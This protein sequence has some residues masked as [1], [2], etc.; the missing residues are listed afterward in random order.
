MRKVL[1]ILSAIVILISILPVSSKAATYNV[2]IGDNLFWEL[3]TESGT[4]V[5][6]GEGAMTE[7]IESSIPWEL[8]FEIS[9]LSVKH[10]II[11]EGV[12]SIAHCA[13]EEFSNLESVVI[14]HTVT[15]I[16][17]NAFY[18]CGK[19]A[20]VTIPDSVTSI[21]EYAFAFCS[22]YIVE[23]IPDSV[24][25]IGIDAFR[26]CVI[27]SD[28]I[29]PKNITELQG[30]TGSKFKTLTIPDSVKRIGCAAFS[31]G[32]LESLTIHD[33]VEFICSEA[34]DR[35][36]SLT[37]VLIGKGLKYIDS[38]AF[39]FCNNL[40]D[41][42][43]V[44]TEEQWESI[45]ISDDDVAFW[46]GSNTCLHNAT[47][48]YNTQ[49]SS[50]TAPT[51]TEQGYTTYTCD[52]NHTVN[53]DYVEPLG[54]DTVI[55][56]GYDVSYNK[57]G[58]TD[59]ISCNRCGVIQEQT[60]IESPQLNAVLNSEVA[61]ADYD[62]SVSFEV[63]GEIASYQWYGCN[64]A[65]KSDKIIIRGA[66][67]SVIKPMDYLSQRLQQSQYK[68]IFCV[69]RVTA[70]GVTQTVESP[71]CVN[72]FATVKETYYS[73]IDYPS[74]TIFSDFG[75]NINDYSNI[76]ELGEIDGAEVTVTP[77]HSS[78]DVKAYGTGSTVSVSDGNSATVFDVVV[79]GDINGDGV[80]DVLDGAEVAKASTGKSTLNGIYETAGDINGD[81]LIDVLDYQE[82]INKAFH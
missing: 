42:Y 15:S 11:C 82:T 76:V 63:D 7:S 41:V 40:N 72:A 34:F 71:L 35:C 27:L 57:T 61:F 55:V 23:K 48:H 16:G 9:L 20:D 77:S 58:L 46:G 32:K 31:F 49:L 73:Y 39:N 50:V 56:E 1:S 69:A 74:Y 4:L 6:S 25:E 59:H 29:F 2:K 37:S 10:V 80:V 28:T 8:S 53:F 62:G 13:F 47:K 68:Y 65:D 17:I 12:T 19:L 21:G 30:F 67:S 45:Y 5:I 51:C 33:N 3:D 78:G 38:G 81:G 79:Y 54:H 22:S 64:N 26:A 66:T 44:G 52:C 14:P 18:K 70:D 60:V 75:N 36:E 43:Y 24:T